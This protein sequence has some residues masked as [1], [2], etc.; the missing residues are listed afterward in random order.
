MSREAWARDWAL[1]P[2]GPAP[3]VTKVFEYTFRYQ[4]GLYT[5]R[6][7][8]D[9]WVS[10]SSLLSESVFLALGLGLTLFCVVY[11]SRFWAFIVQQNFKTRIS[12]LRKD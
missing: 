3:R 10:V 7:Q 4:T 9:L 11:H 8:T 1:S 6:Y 2:S 12:F 5:F